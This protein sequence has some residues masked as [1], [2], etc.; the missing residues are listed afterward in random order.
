MSGKEYWICDSSF[1]DQDLSKGHQV[2]LF[3]I[4]ME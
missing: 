4:S 2:D 3:T 1:K